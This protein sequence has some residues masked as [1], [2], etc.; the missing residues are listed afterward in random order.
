MLNTRTTTKWIQTRDG[1]VI[2]PATRLDVLPWPDASVSNG[3][4]M[5][6]VM[7]ERGGIVKVSERDLQSRTAPAI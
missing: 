4:R 2:A 1:R 5:V 6:F 3:W 7:D